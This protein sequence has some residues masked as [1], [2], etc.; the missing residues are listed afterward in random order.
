MRLAG[1]YNW[2]HLALAV[3]SSAWAAS[4]ESHPHQGFGRLHKPCP[5]SCAENPSQADWSSYYNIDRLGVCG[6]PMLLTF[7]TFNPLDDPRT[8]VKIRACTAGN[9]ETPINALTGTAVDEA[10]DSPGLANSTGAK[11]PQFG[12]GRIARRLDLE[13][14]ELRPPVCHEAVQLNSTAQWI[15][16]GTNS[17]FGE[18]D[19]I[20]KIH[21][22]LR[23]AQNFLEDPINCEESIVYAYNQG[24]LVGLHAGPKVQNHGV[25]T[26]FVED[27]VSRLSSAALG[28]DSHGRA[29][30]QV[31]GAN[32]NSDHHLGVIIDTSGDLVWAQ[33]ALRSW[34]EAECVNKS[35]S[36]GPSEVAKFNVV[37]PTIQGGS[38]ESSR[39]MA[40]NLLQGPECRP[41]L[42]VYGDTIDSLA[43]TCHI[44]IEEL[45]NY[46]RF[47]ADW[48]PTP[49][50]WVCCSSGL[51]KRQSPPGPRPDGSCASYLTQNQDSCSIIGAKNGITEEDIY[52]YNKETYGWGG[53]D[54]LYPG[55]RICLG[56]GTPRMPAPNP[57][58]VCGPTK[59]GTKA[60]IGDEKIEDLSPCP[61]KACCNVWGNCGVDVDFC[62]PSKSETGNPGTAMPGSNGCVQNCGMELVTGSPP[63]EFMKLAYFEAWNKERPCLHMSPKQIPSSYTHVHFSFAEITPSFGVSLGKLTSVFEEFKELTN[64]KRIVAFGGWALSTEPATYHLFR[65]A[66]K[67]ENR[68][69]FAEACVDFVVSNGLDGVDFDWEYPA[70]P[71]IPGIPAGDPEESLNY[72]QF[73]K[74]V[75]A[76]MPKDKTVSIAA[77]ASY[78][79]LKQFLIAEM[80]EY[81]DYIVYM[82]YDL[83]GQWDYGNQWAQSG[84]KAG[85][86]LRSHVNMTETMSALA[87]ITKAGVPSD[88][89]VVGVSSYGRSFKMTDA[90]CSG[91]MC[92]YTGPDSGAAH[93]KCTG[94]GGYISNGEIDEIIAEGRAKK[95]WTDDTQSNYLIY[96]DGE[97]VAYMDEANKQSRI[98]KYRSLNFRGSTDWAVDLQG[99]VGAIDDREIVY[100]GPG[101]YT[102]TPA[103]CSPPCLFVFAP[104]PLPSPTTI[105]I[106]PFSTSIQLSSGITTEITVRPPQ[107]TVSSMSYSNM[108]ISSGQNTGTIRP[109]LSVDVPRV[110]TVIN[111]ETRTLQ[112]PPWPGITNG[113]PNTWPTS[114]PNPN[115][116]NDPNDPDP[117]L[118]PFPIDPP[119]GSPEDPEDPEDPEGP[120]VTKPPYAD[121]SVFPWPT[122]DIAPVPTSVRDEGEDP[123]GDPDD[124][125]PEGGGGGPKH[126][127]TCKLWFFFVCI[128]WD[129]LGVRIRGWE[130]NMPDGVWGPGPIGINLI[131]LPPGFTIKGSLPPW[132]KIT[133]L[134]GG[135]IQAPPKPADCTP[136]EASLCFTT[137]SFA[138]T[139]TAGATR[140]TATQVKSRCATITG[141]NFRDAEATKTVDA[142]TLQRRDVEVTSVPEAIA[143]PE[144]HTVLT[145][146]RKEPNW[147]CEVNGKDYI[148]IPKRPGENAQQDAVR[149]LLRRRRDALS[150][151]GMEGGFEE[152]RAH[153]MGF[154]AL[155]YVYNLGP[156]GQR[157]FAS[158]E[159]PEVRDPYMSPE[160]Y[161]PQQKRRGDAGVRR[162]QPVAAAQDLSATIEASNGNDTES[163]LQML[164]GRA[165]GDPEVTRNWHLSQLSF[166]P[167]VNFNEDKGR[168]SPTKKEYAYYFDDS[169]GQGQT[170]YILECGW[171]PEDREYNAVRRPD[172]LRPDEENWSGKWGSQIA[173]PSD[174]EK[175]GWAVGSF[176]VG[177]TVGVAR[178][179]ELVLVPHQVG[180]P[181]RTG[182]EKLLEALVLVANDQVDSGKPKNSAVVNMS[183]VRRAPAKDDK[184]ANTLDWMLSMLLA[185]MT[186]SYGIAFTTGAGNDNKV[187]DTWPQMAAKTVPMMVVGATDLDGQKASFSSY[188]G[189]VL[190][191]WAPGDG[192]PAPPDSLFPNDVFQGTSFASPLVAGLVA[193]L[194][195]HPGYTGGKSPRDIKDAIHR[196][197]SRRIQ[198]KDKKA[199]L[200][201]VWNGQKEKNLCAADTGSGLLGRRQADSCPLPGGG[202]GQGPQGPQGPPLTYRPGPAGPLCTVNCGKLCTGFYCVPT[203][204][205]TPPDFT[206]PASTTSCTSPATVTDCNGGPR[207]GACVT[208]TTC[209]ST[210]PGPTGVPEFKTADCVSIEVNLLVSK[211]TWYNKVTVWNFGDASK[212]VICEFPVLSNNV[213]DFAQCNDRLASF[214]FL[215]GQ[216]PRSEDMQYTFILDVEL[217]KFR[218]PGQV[219]YRCENGDVSAEC[220]QIYFHYETENPA[221]A[222]TAN[223][224]PGLAARESLCSAFVVATTT[225]TAPAVTVTAPIIYNRNVHG[226]RA[227]APTAPTD[228]GE[229]PAYA[230]ACSNAAAY[231]TA[232]Q[233][234]AGVKPTTVTITAPGPTEIVGGG[235][236]TQGLEYAIYALEESS[237]RWQNLIQAL[238]FGHDQ[239][240][241]PLLFS[242]V[243]PNVTGITPSVGGLVQWVDDWLSPISI[244]GNS[245][246]AGSVMAQTLVDHRG[247]FLPTLSGLYTIYLETADN[248]LY[249][250]IGENAVSGWS[251]TNP[252]ISRFW[253]PEE[254]ATYSYIFE[255]REDQI[256]TAIPFRLLWLNYGGPGAFSASVIDPQGTI[257]LSN[258]TQKSPFVVSSCAGA[259]GLAPAWAA[260]EDEI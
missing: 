219:Y 169:L 93:G 139:V 259:G 133:V 17:S 32:R 64:T 4:G 176:A 115:D 54:G 155:W 149:E 253:P 200:Q 205:G 208:K 85:D 76:K 52:K 120:N 119:N 37:V 212:Q 114:T 35:A 172:P 257:V 1:L 254:A 171:F 3:P 225:V 108:N 62:V 105:S 49:Y 116:P 92:T 216:Y 175:H 38:V 187:I 184:I 147:N 111:G 164:E 250:W 42:A 100:L 234:F 224:N 14:D 56:P 170:I 70:E 249:A 207:G 112:L 126:K 177:K 241:F 256:G 246:P 199:S 186:T 21:V 162:R 44:S 103:Q 11:Y 97:W 45:R 43:S 77:P 9:A 50:E 33:K 252:T 89:I 202:G 121:V 192:L 107:L 189:G 41:V 153:G 22:A 233:C 213:G 58:A 86:C 198:F 25:A 231:W 63:S 228:L 174:Q 180:G 185:R 190:S 142:C 96:D 203:P 247:Y 19:N 18:N 143:K 99:E 137:S 74:V 215:L 218:L 191:N 226:P 69:K 145:R 5:R 258:S 196:H 71:D 68:D 30:A 255:V 160:Q 23:S 94:T 57:E 40:R 80:S 165:V 27:V 209:T 2:A 31:C 28:E 48:K 67:P 168:H 236:C 223:K 24:V 178:K 134:P 36:D 59:P 82:T 161:R 129:D 151:R 98:A 144:A 237:D 206:P 123:D 239:A 91:P 7:A 61:I 46:N 113:P 20:D 78:W 127:T 251:P 26:G 248:A 141:C 128:D 188:G 211:S 13:D 95:Q 124:D 79:Y 182:R 229:K 230:S 163:K 157:F 238:S 210:S 242:G 152:V 140:T 181:Q 183:F 53:C 75:R 245:G 87:M 138:T 60:P 173:C 154:T 240:D 117:D 201:I 232:C 243:Q 179:A 65:N 167:S 83:H 156:E 34:S 146:A 214:S 135:K 150:L 104:S 16:W 235:T 102:G 72:L 204:T 130:W 148:M 73:V 101:V 109:Y 131:K 159:V 132:P 166:P 88:K 220:E 15:S 260:W 197:Y 195:A 81:L 158:N 221:F 136:A 193:Y 217:K 47:P 6:E 39:M 10:S 110:T 222:G 29:V 12:E 66:V 84:C 125:D 194:R 227:P 106:P 122:V 90:S 8:Q 51:R 55:T 244:Y 118:P